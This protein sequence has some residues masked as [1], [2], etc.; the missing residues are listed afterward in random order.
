MKE[1]PI[2]FSTEMVKAILDGSKTQTRRVI[3]PQPGEREYWQPTKGFYVPIE[4]ACRYSPYKKG[5]R[6]WVRETF[7]RRTDGIDQILYKQQYDELVKMFDISDN[8]RP[9]WLPK[10]PEFPKLKWKPSIHMFRK[11]SRITLEITGVRAERLQDITPEDCIAEGLVY[12]EGFSQWHT[13]PDTLV[14]G[15][16]T[17]FQI[18]WD[19]INAKRG[20]GWDTNPFVWVIEFKR[21]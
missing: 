5:G 8:D 20:Y 4:K 13:S 18:L 17:A 3:K 2:I 10:L 14:F 15:H 7:T 12:H 21:L 9:D 11:D 1:K 6:F 16:K 19:S